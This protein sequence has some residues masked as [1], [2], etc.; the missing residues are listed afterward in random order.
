MRAVTAVNDDRSILTRSLVSAERQ[1]YPS[2]DSFKA[3]KSLCD[4]ILPGV[5]GVFGP[6]TPAT[7]DLVEALSSTFHVPFMQYNF[8]YIK[9]RSDFSINV[10]PHPRLLGKAFADFV[11]DVGWKSFIVLYETEDGLVKIQELLKLPRTFADIKITLRQLTPG[12]DDY[13]PLLKEVKKSEETRIVLDCDF[14]KIETILQQAYEIDLLT[15]YHNYLVT[16]LDLDKIN[17]E[18]FGH[19]NA[20]ITGFRLVD[21]GSEEAQLYMKEFPNRGQGRLHPLF[22]SNALMYDAV[23]V[24]GR[25]LTDLDS[26][27]ELDLEPLSCDGGDPWRDGSLL[28]TFLREVEHKGLTGEIKLKDGMRTEF[29][30][31][32]MDKVR[33]RLQKTGIWSRESGVNYTLTATEVGTQMVEKLANKTLRV[34]TTTNSPYVMEKEFGPEVTEEAKNRMSFLER[35]EGFCVDLIKELSK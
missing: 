4:L 11:K 33:G 7:A 23:Q 19:T 1:R 26:L 28:L 29:Q 10:H 3:S 30:L 21:P 22:S 25:A 5:A 14:D 2:D 16:S 24:V 9:S 15:D 20:N 8:E 6:V 13:R 35:Y 27:H 12:T 31:D 32:V 18:Q 17:L 34:V